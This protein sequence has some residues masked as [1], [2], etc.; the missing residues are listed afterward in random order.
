MKILLASI[1]VIP[2]FAQGQTPQ[3]A[4]SV[5][6]AKPAP[7]EGIPV[8]SPLVVSKC[9][10]CHTK[11]QHGNLLRISWE[12]ATPE[13]WEEAIKRMVRLNGVSLTPDEA[14]SIVKYLATYH[15]LAPEEAKPVMYYAEH[16]IQDET[17]IPTDNVRGACA[18][19]HPLARPLS[20]RRSPEDW[21]L[22]A[23]LHIA[24]YPTADEAFR[25][26]IN[27]GG[28]DESRH[29]LEP[30]APL[31]VDEALA[32][33]SKTAP[34]AT[35]EW[36]A[37]RARMRA[38][39]LAGRWIVSASMPGH[40]R[41][42]GYMEVEPNAGTDDQFS[43]RVTLTSVRDGSTVS[44]TG[45]SL[46]YAGYAWRG[47][48]K[49]TPAAN[50]APDDLSS[51]MREVLWFSPD[52]NTAEGRW[53][54]GQYQEFGF[55]VKLQRTSAGPALIGADRSSLKTGSQAARVRLIAESLP[56]QIAPADLDFGTGVTVRRIVSHSATEIVAEVDVA[57]DAVPGKR[58]IAFGRSVLPSAIAV[59]DRIDYVKVV[60][61]SALAR[62]GSETHPKGYQQ[63]D[64]V[65]YQRGADGKSHTADD[66]ELGPIDVNWSVEEF[67]AVYGDDDKEFVGSLS[68]TGFFTPASDGPNPQRKFS[69]NNYGD[70]WVVAT[71]K[72]EKDKDGRP[73][74]GKSYLVVTVPAYI[75]WDQPEVGQ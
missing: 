50:A 25:L 41:F 45:H 59:Y 31:P 70:V 43:T 48:S 61:E 40:G 24:L 22:L 55:D 36:A 75:Q 67:Y 54:W 53:F 74:A 9:G 15:G 49:G 42:Y 11:D 1:L 17:N 38:P 20:W 18:N 65:A 5:E 56:A 3:A 32:F 60:P 63:F 7:E 44:R 37:W 8:T 30:G 4:P 19:C 72:N 64:A 47:R 33:L 73:M 46:V 26:G 10:G 69:R 16:R 68:P 27:A 66:V 62:L 34:L 6:P 28:F 29:H 71:A 51:E 12:R 52:Q 2:L 21:K 13:G 39:K 14:R 23:N 58:D 57:A 35:P